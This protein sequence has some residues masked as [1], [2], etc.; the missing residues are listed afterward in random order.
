MR[1]SVLL[2]Y[3]ATLFGLMLV[4]ATTNAAQVTGTPASW[5]ASFGSISDVGAIPPLVPG[6]HTRLGVN[7]CYASYGTVNSPTATIEGNEIEVAQTIVWGGSSHACALYLLDFGP[8]PAGTYH[9]SAVR[10]FSSGMQPEHY[11]FRFMIQQPDRTSECIHS[12]SVVATL[13]GSALLRYEGEYYGSAPTFGP[14]SVTFVACCDGDGMRSMTVTQNVTDTAKQTY[15]CHGEQINIGRLADGVY[16]INWQYAP[17]TQYVGPP[18]ASLTEFKWTAGVMACS[19]I[20]VF[21][22]RGS[23]IANEPLA[24]VRTQLPS[25]SESSTFKVS[26]SRNVIAVDETTVVVEQPLPPPPY[27]PP[28]CVTTA[29]PLGALP[30][31]NYTVVW[32]I[33]DRDGYYPDEVHQIQL[34]V[35]NSKRRAAH[36]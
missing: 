27:P 2:L 7:A 18:P 30:A 19:N 13:D 10:T 5:S 21:S 24:A 6:E 4:A 3:F 20:P 16:Q 32:T 31:G 28:D 26:Q 12:Q 8:L 15:V 11:D 1:R 33:H 25:R 34:S 29:V 36:H 14:P 17:G 22:I 35:A 23:M 9:V